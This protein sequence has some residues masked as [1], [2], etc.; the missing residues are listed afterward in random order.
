MKKTILLAL[1][2]LVIMKFPVQAQQ[3]TPEFKYADTSLS[4]YITDHVR[5][6]ERHI[7]DRE[8]HLVRF[9]IDP[10]GKVTDI[11]FSRNTDLLIKSALKN[12]LQST[13]GKWK[14]SMIGK[15]SVM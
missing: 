5:F 8:L 3:T 11:S 14:P 1:L 2:G 10:S 15:N 13:S 12:V 6:D 7:C 9:K 4:D